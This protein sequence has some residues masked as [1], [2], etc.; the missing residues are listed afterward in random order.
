MQTFSGGCVLTFFGVSVLKT[1]YADTLI[2]LHSFRSTPSFS[3]HLFYADIRYRY[4]VFVQAASDMGCY[5]AKI[6]NGCEMEPLHRLNPTNSPLCSWCLWCTIH[7][8]NR[9][10]GGQGLRFSDPAWRSH[11]AYAFS[12]FRSVTSSHCNDLSRSKL[13]PDLP[14]NGLGSVPSLS[15]FASAYF[16]FPKPADFCPYRSQLRA[17]SGCSLVLNPDSSST[18]QHMITG[19][20]T[21]VA[22]HIQSV[23]V[24]IILEEAEAHW[25]VIT[26]IQISKLPV[27]NSTANLHL[28]RL[29]THTRYT[30]SAL[31]TSPLRLYVMAPTLTSNSFLLTTAPPSRLSLRSPRTAQQQPILA[32]L[33]FRIGKQDPGGSSGQTQSGESGKSKKPFFFDVDLSK[34]PDLKS[35]V[36]AVPQPSTALS[37]GG[38]RRKDPRTVFVAWATGQAGVRITQ[39]LLRQGFAV[40]AGV[41]QLDAAQELARLAASYKII[42]SDESR[43]LNAVESTFEDPESIAKAI[44]NASKVVV[45]IGPSESGPKSEVT[46][47]DALQVIQAA[48]LA[49]VGHVAIIYDQGPGSVGSNYNV[50]DGITSFFSNIFSR[51]QPLTLLELLDKLVATDV[52]YTLIKASL[53]D[54]YSTEYSDNVVVTAEGATMDNEYKVSKSQIA[55]LVADVFANT[56]IAEDKVVKVSTNPSTPSKPVDELFS[57]IPEDGRRKAYAE[58]LAKAKAEEEALTTSKK[59]EE[60]AKKLEEGA[61]KLQEQDAEATSLAE[62]ARVRAVAVGSSLDDFVGKAK[63]LS[64]SF[65]WEKLGSQISTAI[66]QPDDGEEEEKPKFQIATVRGQAKARTLTAKKAVVKQPPRPKP[67]S[68]PAEPKPKPKPKTAAAEP[69]PEV[70]KVFGGLFKQE[71]IYVD[72]D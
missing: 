34:I 21:V 47:L 69:K 23:P 15:I 53:T 66:S 2:F 45:T 26:N 14:I 60:A 22:V 30:P 62:E 33:N 38:I 10:D 11:L 51:P 5:C 72:D 40:R 31:S 61:K 44:G 68:K 25:N 49:G 50:L 3:G 55:S 18:Q 37:F 54:E 41:P 16:Q 39:K 24:I 4:F 57:A 63:D 56:S 17:L 46:T 28:C 42:S 35:V 64:S 1:L 48:Q 71:T 13:R 67:R 32:K 70:R 20:G 8:I 12:N 65:S 29:G 27:P 9:V 59:A 58:A 19:I 7:W 43:R 36:P 6:I 52:R